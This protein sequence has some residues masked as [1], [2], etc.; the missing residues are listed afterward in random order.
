[1]TTITTIKDITANPIYQQILRD[2]FGGV[3]YN[4]ANRDKYDSTPLLAA[5]KGLS[6]AERERADGIITGVMNFL[7]EE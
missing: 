7:E 5:W 3:M 1:M 2:S 4:V 6:P